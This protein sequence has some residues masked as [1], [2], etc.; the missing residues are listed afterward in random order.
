[1]SL[2]DIYRAKKLGA[3]A[4]SLFDA[5]VGKK[6]SNGHSNIWDEQSE[7]GYWDI[8]DGSKGASSTWYRNANPIP[9]KP[10]TLYC[11]SQ[12][13][14][15]GGLGYL[16]YYDADGNYLNKYT[17][18]ISPIYDETG[19]QFETPANAYIMNFYTNV[20]NISK[21]ICINVS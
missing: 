1:M 12:D 8:A 15:G 16:L 13:E 3:G 20:G 21:H 2:F 14:Q 18:M 6:L 11:I 5:S 4:G 10:N 19:Q 7:P 9:C 17:K